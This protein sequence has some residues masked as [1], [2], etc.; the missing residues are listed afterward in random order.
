MTDIT[1]QFRSQYKWQVELLCKAEKSHGRANYV[2]SFNLLGNLYYLKKFHLPKA[3]HR[4]K[5][6]WNILQ[7]SMPQVYF[8]DENH[9][10]IFPNL[11]E[12]CKNSPDL[13]DIEGIATGLALFHSSIQIDHIGDALFSSQPVRI[14][15][16][17]LENGWK[18]SGIQCYLHGDVCLPNCLF[19]KGKFNTFIDYEE[20]NWGDPIIDFAIAIVECCTV[21][22]INRYQ[23]QSRYTAFVN[24]YFSTFPSKQMVDLIKDTE[25]WKMCL[26]F[27]ILELQQWAE[28][29]DLIKMVKDYRKADTLLSQ[30]NLNLVQ[31][32]AGA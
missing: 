21:P 6:A 1:V 5:Y 26:H 25:Q 24:A 14:H 29:H 19:V 17:L 30:I 8:D 3:Y 31:K 9:C 32:T 4:E 15:H 13:K 28:F 20:S 7:N 23:A 11:G 27:S 12:T 10:A 2:V 18:V 22:S 16:T